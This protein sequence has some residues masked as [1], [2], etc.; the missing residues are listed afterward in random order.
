MWWFLGVLPS[1]FSSKIHCLQ[2]N[3][4]P[5]AQWVLG[6]CRERQRGMR[7]GSLILMLLLVHRLLAHHWGPRFM[8]AARVFL[9]P[10]AC[11]GR[12]ELGQALP[13]VPPTHVSGVAWPWCFMVGVPLS[14]A[15]A[16][17]PWPLPAMLRV[18][19]WFCFLYLFLA[20]RFPSRIAPGCGNRTVWPRPQPRPRGGPRQDGSTLLFSFTAL[21]K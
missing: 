1:H 17:A 21:Q 9:S 12:W 6:L 3:T 20:L 4:K 16:A 5:C 7:E 8:A 19:F 18:T 11:E 10:T 2:K 15:A 13:L 14:P